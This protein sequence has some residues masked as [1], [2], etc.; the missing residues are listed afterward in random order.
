MTT[1]AYEISGM[2]CG[3]CVH[4][5][6]A[7]LSSIPGVHDVRIDLVAGGTSTAHVTSDER[8]DDGAVCAAVDEAGYTVVR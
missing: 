5:V 1:T 2:N 4:A 6:T 3:H 8:L 7:E